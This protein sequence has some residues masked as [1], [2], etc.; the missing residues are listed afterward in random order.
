MSMMPRS[1]VLTGVATTCV[2]AGPVLAPAAAAGVAAT[3]ASS[4]LGLLGGAIA[5]VGSAVLGEV[6][7]P[8]V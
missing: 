2:I 7:F 1:V 8:P 3:G 4:L 5:R 6:A